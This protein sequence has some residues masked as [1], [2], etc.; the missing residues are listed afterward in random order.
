[1]TMYEKFKESEKQIN[2]VDG[3]IENLN[4]EREKISV[5]LCK[6][7]KKTPAEI[8]EMD[9]SIKKIEK[10]D[11]K[12]NY[13]K[14]L[15]KIWKNNRE[16]ARYMWVVPEALNILKRYNG[17]PYGEKTKAKISKEIK[18]FTGFTFY[19]SAFF[20][21]GLATMNLLDDRGYN[22]GVKITLYHSPDKAFLTDD[23]KINALEITDVYPEGITQE[24]I[25]DVEGRANEI[26]T[27]WENVKE[28]EKKLR[29]AE[30]VYNDF[31]I[32]GFAT[33]THTDYTPFTCV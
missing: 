28:K 27:A 13:C 30:K 6:L 10:L 5:P 8:A 16:F 7:G 21:G 23:N 22:S 24:Y 14:V 31:K 12:I 25:E 15:R 26:L 18:D 19:I 11:K 9:E 33:A 20:R 32:A 29:D 17:K 3:A 4:A 1:M 2:M